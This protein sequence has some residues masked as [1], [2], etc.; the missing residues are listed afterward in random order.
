MYTRT[1]GPDDDARLDRWRSGLRG[2]A[3]RGPERVEGEGRRDDAERAKR[4]GQ[5]GDLGRQPHAEDREERT[6]GDR[7][8]EPVEHER[9]EEVR[10]D[11]REGR[12][13]DLDR[14]AS[15]YFIRG[16]S[17]TLS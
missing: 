12:A 11:P 9:E 7:H 2:A 4:H 8:A 15:K 14:D 13:R 5:R 10:A 3:G 1:S 16:K 17:L 6:G